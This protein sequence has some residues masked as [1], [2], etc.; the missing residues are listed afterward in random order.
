M[1][2]FIDASDVRQYE[3]CFLCEP[4]PGKTGMHKK[5]TDC[6]RE[7]AAPPRAI[8]VELPASF[9][10]CTAPEGRTSGLGRARS[11]VS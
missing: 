2:L 5:V 9:G 6:N 8:L 10:L 3:E 7:A 11:S 1:K 4:I